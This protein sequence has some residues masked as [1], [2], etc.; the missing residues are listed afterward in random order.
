VGFCEELAHESGEGEARRE[1]W[2]PEP[3]DDSEGN[4]HR[5]EHEV[6]EW[7]AI[8]AGLVQTHA[9]WAGA[10]TE[11]RQPQERRP[12]LKPLVGSVI[13]KIRCSE[14]TRRKLFKASEM[15]R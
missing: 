1:E 8:E 12:C 7:E 14:W 13:L 9:D 2:T 6:G 11:R 3:S 15:S 5:R 4:P 10:A